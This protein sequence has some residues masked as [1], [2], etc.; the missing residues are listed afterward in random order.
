MQELGSD[1]HDEK[2]GGAGGHFASLYPEA[3]QKVQEKKG[4]F[5]CLILYW[6]AGRLMKSIEVSQV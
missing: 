6:M 5:F 4:E 2:K 1:N 3:V